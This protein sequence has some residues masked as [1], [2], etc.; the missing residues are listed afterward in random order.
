M[1][2]HLGCGGTYLEGYINVDYPPNDQTIMNVKADVYQDINTLEYAD[3]SLDEIRSHHLFEHFNRVD[4]LKLLAKWRRWLKPGGKLVI[5]TPDYFWSSVLLPFAPF[6]FKMRLGR[7]LFGTQE[8]AWANHLDFWD[9]RK[10][11]KV[12]AK[13]GFDNFKFKHPLYRN[14]MPNIQVECRK[15]DM[16]VNESEIIK[17]ILAWYIMP[18]ENTEK[19]MKNWLN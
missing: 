7:H 9:K 19:F 1:K 16:A 5:E 4:A 11:K 15:K 8:A 2:I 3:N 6:F 12:L 14:F 17:E 18:L 13:Y 10:F